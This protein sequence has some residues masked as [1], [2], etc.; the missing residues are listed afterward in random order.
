MNQNPFLRTQINSAWEKPADVQSINNQL[1]EQI[2]RTAETNDQ[3]SIVQMMIGAPGSG[4]TH[5]LTR[6]W[7]DSVTTRKFLFVAIPPPGDI[8]RI[9]IHF[10][11]EFIGSLLEQGEQG[12]L[13]PLDIFLTEILRSILIK[14]LPVEQQSVIE[15]IKNSKTEDLFKLLTKSESRSVFINHSLT[16]F[17]KVFPDVDIQLS[18]ALFALLDPFR[19]AYALKWFQGG[20]LTEQ[21]KRTLNIG[22]KTLD[23]DSAISLTKSLIK[24]S[25]LPVIL[26]I[27]QMESTFYRFNKDGLIKLLDNSLALLQN[28]ESKG[29]EGLLFRRKGIPNIWYI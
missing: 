16:N 23:E 1:T 25:P 24:L 20:E 6:I 21:E 5:L 22:T 4:K 15:K 14:T 29:C 17:G 26:T 8:S 13:L 9:N 28:T 12:S 18:Q 19:K 2:I 11:R 3:G 10:L 27:D 7:K